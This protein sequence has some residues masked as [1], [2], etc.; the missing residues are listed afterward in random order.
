MPFL[1]IL[2]IKG[3]TVFIFITDSYTKQHIFEVIHLNI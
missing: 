3:Q 2:M 1:V